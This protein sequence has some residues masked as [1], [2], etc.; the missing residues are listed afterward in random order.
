[1]K[2]PFPFKQICILLTMLLTVLS[3]HTEELHRIL[4]VNSY[5]DG[6]PSSDDIA[7]GLR[8]G[9][10]G[11][12]VLLETVYLDSKRQPESEQI[13]ARVREAMNFME[14]FDPH[15][16]IASDDN[17]VLH[18]VKPH[19][20]GKSI[21]VVFCGVNWSAEKYELGENVTGMLEVYPLRECIQTVRDLYPGMRKLA[22]LSENTQSEKNNTELLDTLYRNMGMLP[23]YH[24]VDDF[25]AWKEAYSRLSGEADLIYMPTNGAI[26]NWDRQEAM[27]FVAAYLRVPTITCDDFMMDY[28]VFGLTKEARQQGEWAAETALAIL[29]GGQSPADI[30]Y[31]RCSRWH[32]YLNRPLADAL[33]FELKKKPAGTF[34]ILE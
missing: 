2:R 9:L 29:D 16:V 32:A 34:T 14:T 21:P 22:V 23:Q 11:E 20:D 18:V 15:L 27:D 10:E 24:M 1:M 19:L 17:A 30:P 6:Y 7:E 8:E 4:Y 25:E 28:C 31:T 5:H 33:G 12:K 3:C 13:A 26:R